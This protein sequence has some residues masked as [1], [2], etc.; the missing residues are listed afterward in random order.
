MTQKVD[1][2]LKGASIGF[3]L[4]P[5][6]WLGVREKKVMSKKQYAKWVPFRVPFRLTMLLLSALWPK[7]A[8]VFL[9]N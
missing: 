2:F 6:F 8:R 7:T 5:Q 1:Y 3:T 9:N 4:M